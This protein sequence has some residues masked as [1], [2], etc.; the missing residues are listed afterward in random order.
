MTDHELR[1]KVIDLALRSLGERQ[2][3]VAPHAL[4][5]GHLP[6]SYVE[7]E[8]KRQSESAMRRATSAINTIVV[9]DDNRGYLSTF[10]RDAAVRENT[11][12]FFVDA[13]SKPEEG[14]PLRDLVEATVI[15]S[16]V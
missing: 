14:E 5:L 6:T 16:L 4:N 9:T 1:Q 10:V 2:P 7:Q 8:A 11:M 15:G 12:Q 13:W 3:S